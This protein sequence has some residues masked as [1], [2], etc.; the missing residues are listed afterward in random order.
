MI[1]FW[2]GRWSSEIGAGDKEIELIRSV[3]LCGRFGDNGDRP[4][5]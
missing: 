4:H 1:T 3:V 5:A 2:P